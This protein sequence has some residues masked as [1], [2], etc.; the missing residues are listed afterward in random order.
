[1]EALVAGHR[2]EYV[3]VSIFDQNEKRQ[4]EDRVIDRVFTGNASGRDT[5]RP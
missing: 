5:A 3:R 1:M 4:L 2:I